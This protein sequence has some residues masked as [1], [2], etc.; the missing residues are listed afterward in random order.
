MFYIFFYVFNIK[1]Y[2]IGVEDNNMKNI[3][4]LYIISSFFI[5][6]LF[7]NTKEIY[8]YSGEAVINLSPSKSSKRIDFIS[9]T[10][11]TQDDDSIKKRSHKR[12]RKVRRPRQGR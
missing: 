7:S 1:L 6:S 2:Y 10:Y 8:V 5:V 4:K 11:S 9:K 3:L 12:R